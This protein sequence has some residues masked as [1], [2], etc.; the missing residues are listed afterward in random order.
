MVDYSDTLHLIEIAEQNIQLA[1][2]YLVVRTDYAEAKTQLDLQIALKMPEL[3]KARKNIGYDMA[4]I[5]LIEL[6]PENKTN[7][8]TMVKKENEYK[9]LER[10]LNASLNRV[11]LGQSLIKNKIQEG[12]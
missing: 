4:V 9:G 3:S 1:K 11:S 5:H 12:I 10:V 6:Y 8:E 2:Q 7:Y